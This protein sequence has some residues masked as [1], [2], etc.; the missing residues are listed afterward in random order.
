MQLFRSNH[1]IV[2]R[3]IAP[4]RLPALCRVV[5]GRYSVLPALALVACGGRSTPGPSASGADATDAAASSGQNVGS[6][7]DAGIGADPG[8]DAGALAVE[9][10]GSAEAVSTPTTPQTYVRFGDWAPDAPSTGYDFCLAPT[11]TTQWVGPVLQQML[12]AGSLGAGGA[13]G[14]EFPSVTTYLAMTPGTYDL[15]VVQAGSTDC[16]SGVIPA[17]IGLPLLAANAYTTFAVMGDVQATDNDASLKVGAFPDD[18]TTAGAGAILRA[19]NAI[20]S[21]AYIDVGTGS[22]A[23][24]D[25]SSVF[26]DVPFGTASSALGDGGTTDP[27]GYAPFPATADIQFSA[28]ATGTG[29]DSATGTHVAIAAGTVTTLALINGENGGVPPQFLVCTDNAKPLGPLSSCK[30]FPQ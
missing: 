28:Q 22:E 4:R 13:N 16:T 18:S 27:N 15:Q 29:V 8:K 17:T 24:D 21:L 11:G 23:A 9:G 3:S 1:S 19:I 14:L 25:Y 5:A 20:P 30:V 2:S 10:G 6:A 7:A 12:P 26:I